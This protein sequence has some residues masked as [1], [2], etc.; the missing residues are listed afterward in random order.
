MQTQVLGKTGLSVSRLGVGLS[1]IRS[2]SKDNVYKILS[3]ALDAGLN[4]FDTASCYGN[5]E[6]LLGKSMSHLRD[7]FVL[8]SKCGHTS[9]TTKGSSFDSKLKDW[10]YDLVKKSV[11]RSLKL[12]K[13]DHIDIMQIHSCELDILKK[14]EAINALQDAKKEGKILHLGYSGDNDAAVWAA[15]SNIFSTIQTS[16]NLVEQKARYK[17]FE[18][19]KRNNLGVIAKRPIGN[20]VW[21]SPKSPSSYADEYFRRSKILESEGLLS[22]EP[23]NR[24]LTSMGF[25]FSFEEIDSAIIG[26]QN[27]DHMLG[28]IEMFL[29]SL[30]ISV[31]TVNDLC[32]RY[33][34]L[35]VN[36]DQRT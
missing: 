2:S 8:A 7:K 15:E 24:I 6:E 22:D 23:E 27:P 20:G 19:T 31:K 29:K 11:E 33:D 14:G 16:F 36:W 12:L 10:S 9:I 30:P 34:S 26:T 1:E 13:T 17:L 18:V 32:L 3:S 35:G 5:S 25:I 28:N 4:F 21:R